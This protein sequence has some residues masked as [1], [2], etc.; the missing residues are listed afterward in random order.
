M[1]FLQL[2]PIILRVHQ[3]VVAE[4]SL[5]TVLVQ[6]KYMFVENMS[7]FRNCDWTRDPFNTDRSHFSEFVHVKGHDSPHSSKV[8]VQ[9]VAPT[10]D[11]PSNKTVLLVLITNLNVLEVAFNE[12]NLDQVIRVD[13]SFWT[14]LQEFPK[15]PI[16]ENM[17]VTEDVSEQFPQALFLI[18]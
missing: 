8:I 1:N 2:R 16:D 12:G 7:H 3:N 11:C 13:I 9:I 14:D 5:A 17:L 6:E 15:C 10:F 18:I 4:M